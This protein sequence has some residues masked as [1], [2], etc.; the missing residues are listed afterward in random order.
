MSHVTVCFRGIRRT[1]RIAFSV[2]SVG[3]GL[4]VILYCVFVDISARPFSLL[5]EI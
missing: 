2:N 5:L 4:R 3:L 1:Q